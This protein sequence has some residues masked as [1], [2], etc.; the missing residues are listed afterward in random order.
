MLVRIH[1]GLCA[2]IYL[3]QPIYIQGH[4]RPHHFTLNKYHQKSKVVLD[5]YKVTRIMP[6][7]Y[8]SYHD[9]IYFSLVL[10]NLGPHAK[11]TWAKYGQKQSTHHLS[12][13]ANILKGKL[14]QKINW[15]WSYTKVCVCATHV[16][17]NTQIKDAVSP[18]SVPLLGR[19]QTLL[20]LSGVCGFSSHSALQLEWDKTVAAPVLS[21]LQVPDEV[22]LQLTKYRRERTISSCSH[23]WWI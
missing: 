12:V 5:T 7:L 18:L 17:L 15:S 20:S 16:F 10:Q 3:L 9:R 19:S 11:G 22:T 4:I 21:Q 2:L 23:R 8:I 13:A 6:I 14:K 1:T